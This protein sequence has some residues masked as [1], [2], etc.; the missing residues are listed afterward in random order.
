MVVMCY[1]LIGGGYKNAHTFQTH[2]TSYFKWVFHFV[3]WDFASI[4]R[5]FNGMHLLNLERRLIFKYFFDS[6]FKYQLEWI[7]NMEK[8]LAT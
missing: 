2:L 7:K 6:P 8:Y 4:N 3:V 5:F 1:I